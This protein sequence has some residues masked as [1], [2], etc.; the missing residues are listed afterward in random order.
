M[1]QLLNLLATEY[2]PVVDFVTACLTP[3][4]AIALAYIAWRQKQIAQNKLKLDL[5]EKR[6]KLYQKIEAYIVQAEAIFEQPKDEMKHAQEMY[7]IIASSGFL[8]SN[9]RIE[10]LLIELRD[11]G[12]SHIADRKMLENTNDAGKK[13]ELIKRIEEDRQ[14]LRNK[15]KELPQKLQPLIAIEAS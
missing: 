1:C 15:F 9:S 4:I 13:E 12:N 14:K 8:F 11:L 7:D 2:K 10:C 5:F 3:L 6:F